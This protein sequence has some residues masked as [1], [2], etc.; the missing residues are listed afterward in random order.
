MLAETGA[1]LVIERLSGVLAGTAG[2]D[3]AVVRD[4]LDRFHR[5]TAPTLAHLLAL[6]MHSPPSFP[7]LDT[8]LV[9]ID[10]LSTLIDDAYPR[11]ADKGSSRNS[12]EHAKWAQGRKLAVINELISTLARTAAMHDIALLVACQTITRIRGDSRALLVPAIS[13]AGWEKG[14]STRLVLFRDWVPGQGKSI[15][16]DADRLRKARFAGLVKVNGTTLTDEGGVG[17]VVPFVVE[18]VGQSS[19]RRAYVITDA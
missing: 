4:G 16:V 19:T 18:S 6:F 2:T 14:I 1:P 9:V 17:N 10:S 5:F 8:G 7:P 12:S 11:T 13:S 15:D 3:S